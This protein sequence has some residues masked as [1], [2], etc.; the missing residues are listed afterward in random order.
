MKRRMI[1]AT[2]ALAILLVGVMGISGLIGATNA[3]AH[4]SDGEDQTWRWL[5]AAGVVD[6]PAPGGL[7][8]DLST[9]CPDEATAANGDTIEISGEGTLRVGEDGKPK[10]VDGGAPSHTTSRVGARR[11]APGRPRSS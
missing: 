7:L 10:K 8:C 11:A 9:P 2:V 1:R 4:D 3:S 5:A 6:F